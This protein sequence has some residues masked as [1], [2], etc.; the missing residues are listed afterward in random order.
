MISWTGRGTRLPLGFETLRMETNWLHCQ[1]NEQL[2][3]HA[4]A[5]DLQHPR[6]KD[7][8]ELLCRALQLA[9]A[10]YRRFELATPQPDEPLILESEIILKCGDEQE[11]HAGDAVGFV[12]V[13]GLAAAMRRFAAA[14]SLRVLMSSDERSVIVHRISDHN[15]VDEFA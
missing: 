10:C 11:K 6:T 8:V 2:L 12:S 7:S 1:A 13:A 9:P 15:P 5:D 3:P 14:E 4:G